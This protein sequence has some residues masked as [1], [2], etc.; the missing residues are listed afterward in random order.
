MSTSKRPYRG[1]RG[2]FVLEQRD[3]SSNLWTTV[4]GGSEA[5]MRKERGKYRGD[6]RI[7]PNRPGDPVREGSYR[8]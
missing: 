6:L 4:V 5:K 3:T 7:T 2:D 1:L 8:P